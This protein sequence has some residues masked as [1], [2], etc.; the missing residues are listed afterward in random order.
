MSVNCSLILLFTN[1]KKL[2][3]I[4]DSFPFITPQLQSINKYW[5]I[6]FQHIP[7]VSPLLKFSTAIT[8][9]GSHHQPHL[10]YSTSLMGLPSLAL[11][12]KTTAESSFYSSVQSLPME[13]PFLIPPW[14]MSL[15][16]SVRP[17][18]IQLPTTSDLTSYC[19]FPHGSTPATQASLLLDT[20]SKFR[21]SVFSQNS[22]VQ[23][24]QVKLLFNLR[25]LLRHTLS[26]RPSL[27]LYTEYYPITSPFSLASFYFLQSTFHLLT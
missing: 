9:V 26:T 14:S 2:R 11:V 20:P 16:W 27:T 7:G 12:L 13:R 19:C 22:F 18:M 10:C 1:V 24:W 5:W 23:N 4:S 15:K 8:L 21:T 17:W 25:S 3:N 6:Y